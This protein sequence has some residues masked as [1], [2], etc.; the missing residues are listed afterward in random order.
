MKIHPAPRGI[1]Q[2][3]PDLAKR[4]QRILNKLET[5]LRRD[6]R[7][8]R[9]EIAEHVGP[10]RVRTTPDEIVLEAHK[11]HLETVVTPVLPAG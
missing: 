10:I 8:G 2:S 4:C 5:T 6:P 9:T 11:W 3:L 7:R 1:E